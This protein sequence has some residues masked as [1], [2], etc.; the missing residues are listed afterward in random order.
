MALFTFFHGNKQNQQE[1]CVPL[2]VEW[3]FEML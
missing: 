1:V 3:W 2:K